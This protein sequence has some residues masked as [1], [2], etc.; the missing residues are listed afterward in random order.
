MMQ[1]L[2]P[3]Q[4]RQKLESESAKVCFI[5]VRSRDEFG[6]GHVPGAVCV[7]LDELSANDSTIP[8]DKLV[9]LSCQAGLRSAKAYQ[10]LR[11]RGFEN[12][13][14]MAGGFSAWSAA[15]FPVNRLRKTIPLM[16]QVL[17]TA[18]LLVF[19]GSVLALTV[20]PLFVL[21]PL[22]VGAGLSFAGATGWCGLAMLLERMPWNRA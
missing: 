14:E 11:Q 1:K 21:L 5:D 18:G 7:P 9:I 17:L 10:L 8:K 15:G 2:T 4:T 12:V 19:T 3:E 22:F 20:N 16:R 6:S 13:A